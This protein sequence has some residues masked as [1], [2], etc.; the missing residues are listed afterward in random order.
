MRRRRHRV[1]PLA[2]AAIVILAAIAI[3]FYA[4]N[5]GLP[6]VHRF[7]LYALV[8]DSVNVRAGSPVRIAGIDVGSVEGVTAAGDAS[9][10]QFTVGSTGLPVHRDATVRIRDRL[11]L[12]GSYYLELDPGT[13][14]APDL[15]DGDTIP[16]SQTS[17]PVQF[18]EVLSTFDV[19]T[20]TDLVSLTRSL[21]EAFTGSGAA[22]LK[23]A[24]PELT[25]VFKDTAIVSR[26]L[27]GT[28]PG[29][30]ARLLGSASQVTGTLAGSSAQLTD[31]FHGLNVSSAA[32]A[33]SDGALAQSI[34]GVDQTIRA[35]PPALSAIDRA[36]PPVAGLARALTPSLGVAPPI[37]DRLNG[38]VGQLAAVLAPAERGP[39]LSS[40]KAVFEQVPQLQRELAIS[41]PAGRK[42]TDCLLSNVIPVLRETV[43]DGPL[44]T[45][46]PVWQDFLHFLPGIAGAS[47][48]FDANGPYTRTLL[49]AGTNSLTGGSLGTLPIVGQLVGAAPA[50]SGSLLGARPAWIGDLTPADFRPDA[51]CAAQKVPSLNSPVAPPDFHPTGSGG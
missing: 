16:L 20:R 30:V 12:E 11:F 32:L 14:A 2:I 31:L 28:Q 6:F 18:Y 23:R 4:F 25:P 50:G 34:A 1:H 19:A 33:S 5:R 35:L 3:T 21:D 51:P 7:T 17:S 48:N 37:L 38:T 9:R 15:R 39:L 44:S 13:P 46:R 36:L 42:V 40:L 10:I 29:D 47:G 24:I 49:G 8:D 41:F 22:G 45:G 43:P 26:A 27:R